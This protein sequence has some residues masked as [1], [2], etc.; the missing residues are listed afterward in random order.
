MKSTKQLMADHAVIFQA[1][2]VLTAMNG[3]IDKERDVSVA[4]IRSLLAF[5]REFADSCHHV[6]EEAIFFPALIQAGMP[7]QAGPLS[8]MLYEHE[9]A[10]ALINAMQNAIDRDNKK[11]FLLYSTRYVQLLNQHIE[12]E[13]YIL[14]DMAE[15]MLTPDGDE[16]I[17]EE[18]E[19]FETTT[20]GE[21]THAR[22]HRSIE[23]LAAKYG[24][25]A[26]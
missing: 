9:K 22:L 24:S 18:F 14:F 15:Q 8:V 11:E 17:F 5:L 25:A 10:R 21:Q 23:G 19:K 16:K 2:Q 7:A 6:K 1:I 26:A 20:I 3:E 12:K 4:D 13:N